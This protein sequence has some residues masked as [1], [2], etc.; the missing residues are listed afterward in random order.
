MMCSTTNENSNSE[1]YLAIHW[2]LIKYISVPDTI[3][4]FN[5]IFKKPRKVHGL[6]E[7]DVRKRE[8]TQSS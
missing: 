7:V 4:H 2:K 6:K 1:I 5:S 3:L 8:I